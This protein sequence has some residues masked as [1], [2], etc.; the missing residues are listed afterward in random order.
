M[1]GKNK[2]QIQD[3]GNFSGRAEKMKSGDVYPSPQETSAVS[4]MVHFF[5]IKERPEVHM[6]QLKL[7]VTYMYVL[8]I[9]CYTFLDASS[10]S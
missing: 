1:H 5:K 3:G 9:I 10:I 2:H 6:T 7:G 8:C 4:V